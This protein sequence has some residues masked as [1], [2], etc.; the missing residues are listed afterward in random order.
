MNFSLRFRW[1]LA[2][3]A[4]ALATFSPG[5]SQPASAPTGELR[6]LDEPAPAPAPPPEAPPA[7]AEAEA[8]RPVDAAEATEPAEADLSLGVTTSGRGRVSFGSDALLA[9]D[10]SS[11]EVVAIAGNTIV[12]GKANGEAV[13]ILGDT[14]VNGSS[15][16]AVAVLG[17][18]TINGHVQGDVVAV[19]G[20]VQLGPRAVV[21]GEVVSIGGGI[22]RA[23]GAV[24]RGG[25]Q[26]IGFMKGHVPRMDGLRTWLRECLIYGRPLAYDRNLTWAWGIAGV[27]FGFYLLLAL[28]FGR[29]V[30]QCAETL[31]QRPGFTL[32]ASFL[33]MLILPILTVLLAITGVGPVI[34]FFAGLI[35]TLFGKAAFITWLGRRVTRPLGLDL[36]LLSALIGG[37]IL[38]LLYTVPYLGFVVWKFSS[39]VG[40]GMV[41]YTVILAMKRDR[42]AAPAPAPATAPVAGPAGFTAPPPA[43]PSIGSAFAADSAATS[44]ASGVTAT[45]EAAPSVP[46]PPALPPPVPSFTPRSPVQLSTL[47]RAGFW[48]R[49]GAAGID[50]ILVG[51]AAG[52]LDVIGNYFLACLAVYSTAFWA[53]RGT[54]VGGAICGLKVV[55]LDDRPVDWTVAV[56]RALSAFLS[57]VVG[58]LGFIWV[59]FDAERQSWHDKIAGTTIVR[60]PKGTPLI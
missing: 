31:E 14:T 15:R 7:P 41:V 40:L 10:E 36:T 22:D 24:V 11:Q 27:F 9:A 33:T 60:V 44:S 32:L 46:P 57:L 17:N 19:M 48:I 37:V 23:P 34:L 21:E 56:V 42:P 49:A 16:E 53:V 3:S 18:V 28:A 30:T 59:A 1:L 43:A 29:P 8:S 51:V 4:L 45:P 13:A 58:G 38:L 39:V 52:F 54:T 5:W 20:G 2:L 55:R 50:V 6:R 12:D 35:G 47:P 25:V 26:E